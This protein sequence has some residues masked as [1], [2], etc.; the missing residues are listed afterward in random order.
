MKM[1][2]S[3]SIYL[4]LDMMNDLVHADGV[5]GKT[6]YGEQV[7]ARGVIEKTR[8]AIH[9]ARAAGLRIGFVRVGFSPDY[10]E[11]PP[12]RWLK[13][14]F[15]TGTTGTMKSWCWKTAAAR[16]PQRNTR[17][18]WATSSASA[19]SPVQPKSSSSKPR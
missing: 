16:C 8:L 2:V 18:R 7:R 1:T 3:H 13:R 9:K 15:A 14:P 4:V 17:A 6:A 12:N 11:C 19:R 10:R 5:N